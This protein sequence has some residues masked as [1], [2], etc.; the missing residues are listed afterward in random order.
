MGQSAG[1]QEEDQG[2]ATGTLCLGAF[3]QK[4]PRGRFVWEHLD[5]KSHGDALF[6]SVWTEGAMGTFCL[7]AH[8]QGATGTYSLGTINREDEF[9]REPGTHSL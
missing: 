8:C 4:E 7:G 1:G 6:G 3:E 2:G 9:F 5:R